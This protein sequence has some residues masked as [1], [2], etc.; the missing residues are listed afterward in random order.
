VP[1]D[2][3]LDLRGDIDLTRHRKQLAR[4]GHFRLT[5]RGHQSDH[6]RCVRLDQRQTDYVLLLPNEQE[7]CLWDYRTRSAPVSLRRSAQ[8]RLLAPVSAQM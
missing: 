8:T 3:A 4:Q 7:E 2:V 1:G 5:A 6:V